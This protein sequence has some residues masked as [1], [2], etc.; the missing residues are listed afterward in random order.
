[1]CKQQH[2]SFKIK[3]FQLKET[4]KGQTLIRNRDHNLS[5]LNT[6]MKMVKSAHLLVLWRSDP[7]RS[8]TNSQRQT[9][10]LMLR[11]AWLALLLGVES[12][13]AKSAARLLD[14][15]LPG[16]RGRCGRLQT[17]LFPCQVIIRGS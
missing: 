5:N 1:M 6:A 14:Y 7:S 4:A 17:Q 15:I 16:S 13:S 12:V 3:D 8:H 10:G 2:R 11:N 9:E